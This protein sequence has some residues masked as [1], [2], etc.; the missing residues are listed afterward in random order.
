MLQYIRCYLLVYTK[1]VQLYYHK[2]LVLTILYFLMNYLL[3]IPMYL[4]REHTHFRL[5][6]LFLNQ[7]LMLLL[8]FQA[9]ILYLVEFQLY[10][11]LCVLC[12]QLHL[13]VL[14]AL[15]DLEDLEDLL[16]FFVQDYLSRHYLSKK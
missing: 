8:H 14:F 7:I 11:L 15:E 13:F 10:N 5:V 2:V 12:L 4:H 9:L 16:Y 3:L 6:R 1:F